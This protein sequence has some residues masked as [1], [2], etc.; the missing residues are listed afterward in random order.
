MII[1]FFDQM[2]RSLYLGDTVYEVI[3]EPTYEVRDSFSGCDLLKTH[4]VEGRNSS[5]R[6]IGSSHV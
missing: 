6:C 3:A 1:F 4:V 5:I 2:R